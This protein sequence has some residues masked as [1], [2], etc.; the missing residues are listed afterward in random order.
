MVPCLVNIPGRHALF[1][2]F[3]LKGME[4]EWIGEKGDIGV[5][6]LGGLK[7]REMLSGF[8]IYARIIKVRG[9]IKE[10]KESRLRKP[11]GARQLTVLLHGLC[12]SFCLPGS[13]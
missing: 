7:R 1:Y 10:K 2:F 13:F 6:E 4:E 8:N 9:K 5:G 3:F 12:F 11:Q